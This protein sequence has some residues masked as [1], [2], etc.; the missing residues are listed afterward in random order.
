MKSKYY[1]DRNIRLFFKKNE[2]KIKIVKALFEDTV[3][4]KTLRYK[5]RFFLNSLSKFGI[6]IRIKNRCL[7]TSRSRSLI[8]P[9]NVSRLIFRKMVSEG[10]LPGVRKS[11]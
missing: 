6:S 7:L 4:S 10:S 9:F 11:S 5:L 3:L 2:Y 8:K 1:R